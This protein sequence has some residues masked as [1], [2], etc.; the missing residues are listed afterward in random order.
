[1]ARDGPS[2]SAPRRRDRLIPRWG[3]WIGGISLPTTLPKATDRGR[4]RTVPMCRLMDT[5][6]RRGSGDHWVVGRHLAFRGPLEPNTIG[7]IGRWAGY[8]R[9]WRLVRRCAPLR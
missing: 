8:A 9:T 2:L 1:M 4:R 6:R 5:H 3:C 7:N